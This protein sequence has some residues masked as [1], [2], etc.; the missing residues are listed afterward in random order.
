[1]PKIKTFGK[2]FVAIAVGLAVLASLY[3]LFTPL[4]VQILTATGDSG[5]SE[6]AHEATIRQSWY[7][8]QG[9]WGI[10]VL[11]IV[12]GLYSWGYYLARKGVYLWLG[13]LS[14]GLLS[15]SYLA[16]FSIGV[17]YFPAALVLLLGTG[18]LI[19]SRYRQEDRKDA[20]T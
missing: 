7:Q 14:L 19:F 3:I 2:I 6:I 18:L 10:I 11:L 4:D 20:S 8:V 16:G 12:S 13:V 1:M 17:L 15:L 5:G 9:P